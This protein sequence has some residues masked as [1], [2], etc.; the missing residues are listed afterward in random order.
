MK[1]IPSLCY[2]SVRVILCGQ[3]TG[4]T[5][6]SVGLSEGTVEKIVSRSCGGFHPQAPPLK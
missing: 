3:P 4:L 6:F 2:T 1:C 5:G